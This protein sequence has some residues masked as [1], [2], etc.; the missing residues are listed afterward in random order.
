MHSFKRHTLHKCFLS[1]LE[2]KRAEDK[3][4]TSP[5]FSRKSP[6]EGNVRMVHLKCIFVREKFTSAYR[7]KLCEP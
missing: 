4:K 7:I 5:Y 1:A 3:R 2:S 6:S